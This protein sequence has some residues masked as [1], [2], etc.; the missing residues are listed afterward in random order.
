[1]SSIWIVIEAEASG[2]RCL[3]LN[4]SRHT[5]KP[6]RPHLHASPCPGA[7]PSHPPYL[8]FLSRGKMSN[9][10]KALSQKIV[11]K[12]KYANVGKAFITW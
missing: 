10:V 5:L 1:M 9:T 2:V 6:L 7:S 4:P 3:D 12:I 11:A 8:H